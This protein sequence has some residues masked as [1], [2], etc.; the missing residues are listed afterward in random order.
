[1]SAKKKKSV[2]SSSYDDRLQIRRLTVENRRLGREVETLKQELSELQGKSAKKLRHNK[3][4]QAFE[5]G[6][7]NEYLF[8]KRNY[9]LYVYAHLK[10]T[11]VFQ[12]YRKII[13]F[14]K[15]YTFITTSIKVISVLF[16]FVETAALV[17]FSTSVFVI[18]LIFTLIASHVLAFLTIFT[19]Q[20]SNSQNKKLLKGKN[21]TVFF[22]PKERAFDY[23]SYFSGFVTERAEDVRSMAV[24]VSPYTVRSL[25]L[26]RSKGPYFCSRPDGERIL[27]VRKSYYFI[28]K[29]IIDDVADTVTEIF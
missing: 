7:E 13:N 21:V 4:A 14:I 11:S 6:T 1:M 17:V 9:F 24:I 10:R 29:K 23:E 25:G 22:P 3:Y 27:L 2:K 28:L 15:R 26:N 19:R 8:S 5:H 12:V 20:K 18:S 16:V